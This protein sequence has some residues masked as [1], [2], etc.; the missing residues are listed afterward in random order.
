MLAGDFPDGRAGFSLVEPN[1]LLEVARSVFFSDE[2][3]DETLAAP[4]SDLDGGLGG[5]H[6]VSPAKEVKHAT[7]KA[8]V[9]DGRPLEGSGPNDPVIKGLAFFQYLDRSLSAG[10]KLQLGFPLLQKDR[11]TDRNRTQQWYGDEFS[12]RKNPVHIVHVNG[13]QFKVRPFLG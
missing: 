8:R 2:T 11:R 7:M 9:G 13:K 1:P 12:S 10:E 3:V 6:E 4:G 5:T